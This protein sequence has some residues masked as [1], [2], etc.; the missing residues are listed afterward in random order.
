MCKYI[1][2]LKR[3]NYK[4]NSIK[5]IAIKYGLTESELKANLKQMGAKVF[6][7]PSPQK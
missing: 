3:N 4:K 2:E 5:S 1:D 6:N 7:Y